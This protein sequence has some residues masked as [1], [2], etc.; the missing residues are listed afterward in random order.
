MVSVYLHHQHRAGMVYSCGLRRCLII[1]A[2]HTHIL[3]RRT[4]TCRTPS[5]QLVLQR[6]ENF[7]SG[8][9]IPFTPSSPIVDDRHCPPAAQVEHRTGAASLRDRGQR[10]VPL[11]EHQGQHHSHIR[12]MP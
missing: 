8:V 5:L 3:D 9:A 4:C 2:P 7:T 1:F 6:S 12:S 10:H 11:D